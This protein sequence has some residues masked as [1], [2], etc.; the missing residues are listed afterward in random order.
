MFA[1]FLLTIAVVAA[2]WFGF[3]YLQRLAELKHSR[4]P[5]RAVPRPG[6]AAARDLVACPVCGVWRVAESCG[7]GDCPY[8]GG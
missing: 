4:R 7:R 8:R 6:R 5:G 2:I 1:K 3:Q